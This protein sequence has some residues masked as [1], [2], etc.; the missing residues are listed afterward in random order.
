LIIAAAA[1]CGAFG[2][3]SCIDDKGNYDYRDINDVEFGDFERRYTVHSG[4]MLVITPSFTTTDPDAGDT[5]TYEWSEP[6]P[7]DDRLYTLISEEF[8]LR[9]PIKG[10]YARTGTYRFQFRVKNNRTG[11]W[12]KAGGIEVST[13]SNTERGFLFLTRKGDGIGVD[14]LANS[15]D[16]ELGYG[17][18]FLIRDVLEMAPEER[19]LATADRRGIDIL[20]YQ[21]PWTS[22]ALN[23]YAIW[24]LTDKGA[25][26]VSNNDFSWEPSYNISSTIPGSSVFL[27]NVNV[28]PEKMTT[29]G[30]TSFYRTTA[31]YFEN[32]WYWSCQRNLLRWEN[33][34]NIPA[35]PNN[36]TFLNPTPADLFP[37]S[38]HAAMAQNVYVMVMWSEQEK[39][40]L[41]KP[42]NANTASINNAQNWYT[43][44]W[45]EEA[46]GVATDDN[47]FKF[48]HPYRM[49]HMAPRN[50]MN[51]IYAIVFDPEFQGG[52][53]RMLQM[54]I[55]NNAAS[56]ITK[57]A[58]TIPD[59]VGDA[60]FFTTNSAFNYL[61]YVTGDNR[62]WSFN[63]TT[64]EERELTA[65]V[66][67]SGHEVV[68]FRMLGT[69]A[70]F[71][72]ADPTGRFY[73][74]TKDPALP[75]E[76]CC[77]LSVYDRVS[78][79]VPNL[80]YAANTVWELV[81]GKS[82]SHNEP[83]SV[84]GIGDVIAFTW[85]EK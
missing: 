77:T 85:K 53:Y 67:P 46:D 27:N 80:K 68:V 57:L 48:R 84:S 50:H 61:Y 69:E 33:P 28:V 41:V 45:L 60:K 30:M 11:I 32:N 15:R 40:F 55:N 38:E 10:R 76:S 65:D 9:L 24:V 37:V 22:K 20:A 54:Q 6:D 31:F 5:F 3:V 49:I 74:V 4:D 63:L 83:I 59:R 43:S 72:V 35:G 2:A 18:F 39:R 51:V 71:G 73:V 79:D 12:Y 14:M 8:E 25:E 23:N 16:Y 7:D 29:H 62:V 1:L 17:R 36:D 82:V 56:N 26:R 34:C 70:P 52:K 81:D 75:S 42:G 47:D 78:T 66:V 21:D 19:R 13:T 64:G 58:W 44:R